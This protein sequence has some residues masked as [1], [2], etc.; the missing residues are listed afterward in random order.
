MVL[1]AP[2]HPARAAQGQVLPCQITVPELFTKVAKV[3]NVEKEK[4]N[5]N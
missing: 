1:T 5:K 3:H 2:L 4:Y